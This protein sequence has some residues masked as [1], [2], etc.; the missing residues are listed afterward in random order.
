MIRNETE[1]GRD[2]MK[3]DQGWKTLRQGMPWLL[4]I[5]AG[6]SACAATASVASPPVQ[7]K[8][9]IGRMLSTTIRPDPDSDPDNPG[10]QNA[11]AGTITIRLTC[12]TAQ[13]TYIVI[14]NNAKTPQHMVVHSGLGEWCDPPTGIDGSQVLVDVTRHDGEWW[15]EQA[16][17]LQPAHDGTS[18]LILQDDPTICGIR[19]WTL[20]SPLKAV[21][22]IDADPKE[23]GSVRTRKLLTQG[24]LHKENDGTLLYSSAVRM[25]DLFKALAHSSCRLRE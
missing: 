21:D 19:L 2:F 1:R 11:A 24:I 14:A 20:R 3:L 22:R 6:M 4:F 7:E 16:Y 10:Q 8:V 5:V 18:I 23:L 9:F 12:A 17:T 15:Q 13:T 25:P